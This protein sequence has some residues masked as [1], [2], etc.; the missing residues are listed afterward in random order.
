MPTIESTSHASSPSSVRC[1]MLRCYVYHYKGAFI[2]ECIDL[3]L[4]VEAKTVARAKRE[5]RDAIHGYIEAVTQM[6][7]AEN[8]IPR[9]APL[10]HRFHYHFIRLASL[11]HFPIEMDI[12]ECSGAPQNCHV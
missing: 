2:G 4:A 12:Y 5:L 9:P 10:S 7:E 11:L 6:G 3:D 1:Q 8:L